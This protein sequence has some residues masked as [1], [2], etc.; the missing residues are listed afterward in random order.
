MIIGSNI[1]GGLTLYGS[2]P[3]LMAASLA[4]KEGHKI[5]FGLYAKKVAPAVFLQ[6]LVSDFY[7]LLLEILGVL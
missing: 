7:I 5:S 4:E 3:V 1:G 6:L 2:V